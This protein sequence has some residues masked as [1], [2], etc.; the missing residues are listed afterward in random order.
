MEIV[1][2]AILALG[3]CIAIVVLY[4]AGKILSGVLEGAVA[5]GTIGRRLLHLIRQ[6]PNEAYD[7]FRNDD[8]WLVFDTSDTEYVAKKLP[9]TKL[10]GPLTFVVPNLGHKEVTVYG[11]EAK[12]RKS[13]KTIIDQLRKIGT[14]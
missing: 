9:K 8:T 7:W 11:I 13:Q 10:I 14:T 3:I 12:F 5:G 1:F 6:H 2:K 4:F